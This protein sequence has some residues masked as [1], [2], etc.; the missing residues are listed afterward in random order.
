MRNL[1]QSLIRCAVL[2]LVAVLA[3]APAHGQAALLLEEPY[4]W[5]GAL[6]PTGHVATYFANICAE[7]PVE[8]RRCAP[9]EPGSVVARY[10]G[11]SGY[12]WVAIPLVPYLYAVD[13]T[14][15]VPDHVDHDLVNQM[16]DRY[17]ETHLLSL[18]EKLREGNIVQGGWGQLVGV[19][20]D[21]RI[22]AFRFATTR[23]QDDALIEQLNSGKNRSRFNLLYNNCADFARIVLNSYF[24][25][26][27]RRSIFPDAGMTTPKQI[28]YKL[29]RYG[30]RHPETGLTVLDIAQVPGYRRRSHSN[31]SVAESLSTTAYAV[32]ILI[33]NPYLGGA[34]FV[35]YL[36][37]GHFH[38]VP[39]NAEVVDASSL[40]ALTVPSGSP[41]T[42]LNAALPAIPT[43]ILDPAPA[44]VRPVTF[45]AGKN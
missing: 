16:R 30:R 43:A 24:P 41:P 28:A 40:Y 19:A 21:R 22:Y 14:A 7:T 33:A 29:E 6:N 11:M 12:D 45:K 10:Q 25:H 36:V 37:Q 42:T 17:H 23:A 27:F 9:G 8:L 35:D 39:K 4:G 3:T 38:L 26:E 13:S 20:Y 18:G 44:Q 2:A 32:P 5:F 31:Q 34:L 1:C 15:R